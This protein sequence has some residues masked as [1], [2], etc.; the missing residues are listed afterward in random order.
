LGIAPRP[1]LQHPDYSVTIAASQPCETP[2]QL[3]RA[4]TLPRTLGFPQETPLFSSPLTVYERP[5]ILSMDFNG[6]SLNCCIF[7]I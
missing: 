1:A 6:H 4:D 5:V 3:A 7:S 2:I